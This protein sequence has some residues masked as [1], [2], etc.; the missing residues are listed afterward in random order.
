MS[1]LICL[2]K[3]GEWMQPYPF[4]AVSI[5]VELLVF[6]PIIFQSVLGK[7]DNLAVVSISRS[8]RLPGSSTFLS[9]ILLILLIF[10]MIFLPYKQG[11]QNCS[12]F[13]GIL[14]LW[15]FVVLVFLVIV[16]NPTYEGEDDEQEDFEAKKVMPPMKP[17]KFT[18]LPPT[19]S[20]EKKCNPRPQPQL[21][22]C[23]WVE[24]ETAQKLH[25]RFAFL[26]FI[27]MLVISILVVSMVLIGTDRFGAG[28]LIVTLMSCLLVSM[29]A[30][31]STTYPGWCPKT[32][33]VEISY[34]VLFGIIPALITDAVIVT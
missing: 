18:S 7:T 11:S 26:L 34:A 9:C 1:T 29:I 27:Y 4:I 30:T 5:V 32:S 23:W 6:F 31:A 15:A 33:L 13:G 19:T 14:I 2:N 12:S 17:N 16:F 10:Y 21:C 24:G 28:V 20:N 3:N 22:L 25:Q 8:W